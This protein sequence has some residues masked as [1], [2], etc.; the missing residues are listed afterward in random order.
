MKFN[1]VKEIC[2]HNFF[3]FDVLIEIS[4]LLDNNCLLFSSFIIE[5]I[6]NEDINFFVAIINSFFNKFIESWRK[7]R[8]A[9][10]ISETSLIKT[11]FYV[12]KFN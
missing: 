1:F 7:K 5:F 2:P 3:F 11:K 8:I 12:G 6:D 4:I 10:D 9:K